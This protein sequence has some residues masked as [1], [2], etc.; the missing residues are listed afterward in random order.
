MELEWDIF[1][2]DAQIILDAEIPVVQG[3]AYFS[4]L[5]YRDSM[6]RVSRLRI[7]DL[8]TEFAYSVFGYFE[9]TD[10][11]NL[12]MKLPPARAELDGLRLSCT[13]TSTVELGELGRHYGR[14][15]VGNHLYRVEHSGQTDIPVGTLFEHLGLGIR[16]CDPA[17]ATRAEFDEHAALRARDAPVEPESRSLGLPDG[18][19]CL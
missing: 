19:R 10:A 16:P 17:Q 1:G 14:Y 2:E 5:K 9:L 6:Y 4:S 15:C 3:E 13:E 18:P 12:A 8:D 7:L 11:I